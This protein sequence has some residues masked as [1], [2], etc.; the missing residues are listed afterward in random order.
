MVAKIFSNWV[1]AS[2][3]TWLWSSPS[4]RERKA[5]C[6][7]DSSPVTYSVAM[8]PRCK[9]SMACSSKVDFPMP[10]SPPISTTPPATSPP[11]ST[12]SSSSC[13]VGVRATSC[14]SMSASVATAEAGASDTRWL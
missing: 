14:A 7:P 9:P 2:T 6:A 11:P 1:S 8:P 13:P 3:C 5:T 4:R 12:R 10:G